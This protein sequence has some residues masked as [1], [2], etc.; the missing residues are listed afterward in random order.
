MRRAIL[1]AQVQAAGLPLH[2]NFSAYLFE[3]SL[4]VAAGTRV[5]FER[6][7]A[8]PFRRGSEAAR[9]QKRNRPSSLGVGNVPVEVVASHKTG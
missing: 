2:A 4:P 9:K 5:E 3:L 7:P 1:E 8:V 6:R